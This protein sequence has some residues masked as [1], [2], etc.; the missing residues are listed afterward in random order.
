L[1]ADFPEPKRQNLP[2]FRKYITQRFL[3]RAMAPDVDSD[4]FIDAQ[5]TDS[6]RA[7][8]FSVSKATI[9]GSQAT[10]QVAL[11]GNE[12]KYKLRVTLR[13][14]NGVWKIDSV[15]GILEEHASGRDLSTEGTAQAF[16]FSSPDLLLINSRFLI[17]PF[18]LK[19]Q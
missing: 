5:D 19:L 8:N 1:R 17:I 4:L 14:E 7:D 3:K 11:N 12:M 2:T 6:T 18:R 9:G 15:K 13:R 10:V 16:R